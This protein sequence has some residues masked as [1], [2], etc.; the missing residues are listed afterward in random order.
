MGTERGQIHHDGHD[1]VVINII[2]MM[3]IKEADYVGGIFVIL[4]MINT[5]IIMMT[6][7]MIM[8]IIWKARGGSKAADLVGGTRMGTS[9]HLAYLLHI[10]TIAVIITGIV[11]QK[12]AQDRDL[13][14]DYCFSETDSEFFETNLGLNISSPRH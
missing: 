13:F 1:V 14:R 8:M 11:T 12:S 6:N 9:C 2:I 10:F 3:M 5:T 4:F 7:M